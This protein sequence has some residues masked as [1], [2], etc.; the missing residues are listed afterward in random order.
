MAPAVQ[1]TA[2]AH[3]RHRRRRHR[4]RRHRRRHRRRRRRVVSVAAARAA[5]MMLAPPW[6][7]VSFL[8][9]RVLRGRA[10]LR[11]LLRSTSLRRRFAG[12]AA[13]WSRPLPPARPL[14]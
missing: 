4:R 12:G 5:A 14:R 13:C 10:W 3:R 7:F 8:R 2:L 11:V 9:A 6:L 1:P